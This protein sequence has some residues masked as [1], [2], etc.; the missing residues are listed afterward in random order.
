MTGFSLP[1]KRALNTI[2]RLRTEAGSLAP[3]RPNRPCLRALGRKM[4]GSFFPPD[5]FLSLEAAP[6]SVSAIPSPD[7]MASIFPKRFRPVVHCAG[8][9][10]IGEVFPALDRPPRHCRLFQIKPVR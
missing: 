5:Q 6:T 2:S 8:A 9:T 7:K 3:P 4:G 1:A 10:Q